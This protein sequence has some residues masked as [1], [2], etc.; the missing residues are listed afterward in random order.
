MR[1]L[2]KMSF[3]GKKP[4]TGVIPAAERGNPWPAVEI[5]NK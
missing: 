5:G 1:Q 2:L 3:R 4:L